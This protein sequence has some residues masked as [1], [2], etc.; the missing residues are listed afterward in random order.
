[1][2]HAAQ[3]P[4]FCTGGIGGVHRDFAHSLDV[5]ADLQELA[6]TPVAVV[7]SGVKSILDIGKTLEYLETLGV[8]VAT[9]EKSGSRVFPSFFTARSKF[10]SAYNC[11][12]EAE[13]ARLVHANLSTGFGAGLLIA[14]PIPAEYSASDELIEQAIQG[15]LAEASRLRIT[16]KRVT[17]FLLERI[18]QITKG[19]SLASN[20]ALI[21]NNAR[22]SGRI[23]VELNKI[24]N[25][26]QLQN[27]PESK[28]K[29]LFFSIVADFG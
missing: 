4:L 25:E 28:A 12:D 10:E 13:A 9:L 1:M 16:G 26:Q 21:K 19:Q 11:R 29:G 2:A 3:I 15:A 24:R 27:E 14:V 22:V 17:P 18:S 7:S 8:C 5:S 23:A 6:R 20:L